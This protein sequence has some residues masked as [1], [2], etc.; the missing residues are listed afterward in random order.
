MKM[1]QL[2]HLIP[3]RDGVLQRQNLPLYFATGIA[4]GPLCIT[5]Y[6]AWHHFAISRVFP[7]FL[8]QT[9]IGGDSEIRA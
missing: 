9:G 2:V 5:S 4:T 7:G 1:D 3:S 8:V 6:G